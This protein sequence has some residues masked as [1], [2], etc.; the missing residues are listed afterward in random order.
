MKNQ[1]KRIQLIIRKQIL[2]FNQNKNN[3]EEIKDNFEVYHKG[4]IIEINNIGDKYIINNKNIDKSGKYEL[5]I[6]FKHKLFSLNSFFKN[7]YDLE[8]LDLSNFDTSKVNDMEGMFNHCRKLK[9]IKGLEKFITNNVINMRAMF[10][11]CKE[12]EYLDLTN[13]DTSKVEDMEA[14]FNECKNLK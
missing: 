8:Y 2:L 9:E 14:M 5:R 10:Q 7:C 6:I 13:F 12:I 11:Y 3:K 4:K 1:K